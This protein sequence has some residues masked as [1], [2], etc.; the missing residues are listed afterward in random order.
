MVFRMDKKAIEALGR[1]DGRQ[2]EG[3]DADTMRDPASRATPHFENRATKAL[4]M[5]ALTAAGQVYEE[6][7]RISGMDVSAGRGMFDMTFPVGQF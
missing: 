1:R 5:Y 6:E 2:M 7:L 4:G 3:L